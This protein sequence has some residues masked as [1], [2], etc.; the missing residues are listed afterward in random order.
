MIGSTANL[1]A[2]K[3]LETRVVPLLGPAGKATLGGRSIIPVDGFGVPT[4]QNHFGSVFCLGL[5]DGS[6]PRENMVDRWDLQIGA[7]FNHQKVN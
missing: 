3:M 6:F 2:M 5:S 1:Q 7:S 4:F